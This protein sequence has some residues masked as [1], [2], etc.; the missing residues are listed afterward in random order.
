MDKPDDDVVVSGGYDALDDYDFMWSDRLL[1]LFLAQLYVTS[2]SVLCQCYCVK[3]VDPNTSQS[4][5]QLYFIEINY[6]S[7]EFFFSFWGF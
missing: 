3:W 5:S 7:R 4:V 1:L 2:E 6:I